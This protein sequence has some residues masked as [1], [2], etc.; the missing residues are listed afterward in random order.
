MVGGGD[1]RTAQPLAGVTPQPLQGRDSMDRGL[2]P[3]NFGGRRSFATVVGGRA[4]RDAQDS[5]LKP[6]P[7]LDHLKASVKESVWIPDHVLAKAREGMN[8]VLFGKIFGH[9]VDSCEAESS[10]K[11]SEKCGT[12]QAIS[13]SKGNEME[14][15]FQTDQMG[16]TQHLSSQNSTQGPRT[17]TGITMAAYG[18]WMTPGPRGFGKYVSVTGRGDGKGGRGDM[19]AGTSRGGRGGGRGGRGDLGPG[20]S[21]NSRGNRFQ[22]IAVDDSPEL[23]VGGSEEEMI[24]CHTEQ[25]HV[26]DDVSPTPKEVGRVETWERSR[27]RKTKAKHTAELDFDSFELER[28][29]FVQDGRAP[30]DRSR[31]RGDFLGGESL[32]NRDTGRGRVSYFDLDRTNKHQLNPLNTPDGQQTNDGTPIQQSTVGLMTSVETVGEA[33]NIRPR[34]TSQAHPADQRGF[35]EKN[36]H[37]HLAFV[38]T[39]SV[40]LEE[41]ERLNLM[42]NE[43]Y[44][45]VP[46]DGMDLEVAHERDPDP[47][48]VRAP[49]DAGHEAMKVGT[50]RVSSSTTPT[51]SL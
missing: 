8:R 50:E 35:S 21:W 42:N 10:G 11:P 15:E 17:G 31:E 46:E 44:P 51:V 49:I 5:V 45:S 20:N 32:Q 2:P 6:G 25:T 14:I 1:E 28:S 22:S 7:L 16:N 24:T 36:I 19:G 39:V 34:D 30:R 9:T 40:A 41:N 18:V 47:G 12:D 43:V 27:S 3:T 13:V 23:A 29:P 38:H 26:V 48:V 33:I 37:D 4:M